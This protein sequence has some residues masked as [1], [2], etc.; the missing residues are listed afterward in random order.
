MK[1]IEAININTS[2]YPH[3]L[4]KFIFSS[5]HVSILK[6][7]LRW[8]LLIVPVAIAIGSMVALFLW[9]LSWA[10]HFRFAHTWLLFLLPLAGV[11]IHFIYQWA[12]KSSE[13]GNNLI[14]DEIHEPGAGVPPRMG[15]IILINTVITHL[16]GGSAGREGTAVQIGGS[17]AALFGNWFKLTGDDLRMLLTAG[18]AA[19]F[20]AVF[21]TP[22]TGAVFALEVLTIGR[23]K[24]DALLP[25]L[26]ASIVAD[27]TVGAWHIHHTAYHIDIIAKAPYFLSNYLPMDLLLIAKV[28]LASIAFGL[29]SYLFAIMVHEIKAGFLKIFSI[30]WLIPAFGGL[31]IIGLTYAIGKPDYLSL[32]V[33]AQ[34]PGAV[35]IPSS[36]HAGGADTWSWLW[37]IIYTTITLGTGFK[38]GEVTPLFY[39]GSTLGNTLSGLLN[40]PV[41]LFA[42]LGFIAVFAGAT[43]T[44][45]ACTFMG[46]ELFGGEYALLFAIACFTA[47]FFSGNSGIYSSQ[48]IAVPKILDSYFSGENSLGE[49]NKR[50]GYIHQKLYKYRIKPLNK[51]DK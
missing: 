49:A 27:I 1:K 11:L 32:G 42:A 18:I 15:P 14:I 47:Y 26:I 13:K 5:E 43:N 37:K 50:R 40:A 51:T 34:Y 29:A 22:L 12:G 36:F 4:K 9:L 19:G 3:Q 45:L 8:T 21:G 44:P 2:R 39:I 10:I 24:Y 46:V 16:F 25:A 28:I 7:T 48:T 38:G 33:D 17:I 23:I 30:K 20:G 31:I 41:S 6:Y 35:T